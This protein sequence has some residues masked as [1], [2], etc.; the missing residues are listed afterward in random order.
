VGY[1]A[2]ERSFVTVSWEVATCGAAAA[3]AAGGI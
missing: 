1:A 3:A 2:C